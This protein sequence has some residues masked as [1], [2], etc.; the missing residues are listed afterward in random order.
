[1]NCPPGKLGMT[2]MKVCIHA[3]SEALKDEELDGKEAA[4]IVTDAT[5]S[6]NAACQ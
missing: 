3:W 2:F 4:G 6:S 1:M 5:S